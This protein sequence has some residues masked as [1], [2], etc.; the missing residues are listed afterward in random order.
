MIDFNLEK[1]DKFSQRIFATFLGLS[2]TAVCG[3][4]GIIL[5]RS[6][7]FTFSAG[8]TNINIDTAEEVK[9]SSNNLEYANKKLRE[10]VILLEADIETL[11]EKYQDSPEIK[12]LINYVDESLKKIES[13]A[14]EVE[15][16]SVKLKDAASEA[17]EN[18]EEKLEEGDR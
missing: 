3:S 7:T 4:A 15:R 12:E 17:I 2:L 13:S 1:L 10:R 9:E 14:V 8:Q 6:S 11:K 16:N 18:Q 5:I